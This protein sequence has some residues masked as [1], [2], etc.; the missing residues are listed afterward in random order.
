MAKF[1][2]GALCAYALCAATTAA[3]PLFSDHAPV[4]LTL[5]GP[6]HT[7][8]ASGSDEAALPFRLRAD[9]DI[10]VAVR[11]RGKSRQRVCRFPPLRLRFPAAQAPDSVFAGQDKLKLVTHCAEG[12][13]ATAAV[14]G[15]Y[16]AYRILNQLTPLGYRVRLARI[17]YIDT[18][19]R[20]P[21]PITRPG[22]FIESDEELAARTGLSA[23]DETGITLGSLDPSH[24]A[25]VFVFQ[26]LVGNTDWSLVMADGDTA[27][28]HNVDVFNEGGQR[29][30][31]P[32]DFDLAG[33]AHASYAKPDPS[34]R[35][36]SVTQRLYRGYCIPGLPLAEAIERIRAERDAILGI[37]GSAPLLSEKQKNK[38][39][40]FLEQFYDRADE[41]L[42]QVRSFEKR[43]L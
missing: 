11:I 16:A 2:F 33:L 40:R 3:S 12:D 6:L 37:V 31:V 32:Y 17:T 30:L 7:L 36:G 24:T 19:Q 14:I 15:E 35:I 5:T 28:C 21:A 39:T 41:P 13:R 38:K 10:R 1:A 34:L 43:C 9:G 29:F 4:E 20:F 18:D 22:F 26:Y 27:C 8:F 23:V 25:L 42:R